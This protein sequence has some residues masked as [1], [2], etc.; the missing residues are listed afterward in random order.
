VES[1][2]HIDRNPQP[3]TL[4]KAIDAGRLRAGKKKASLPPL[5]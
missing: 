4:H 2:D 3:N 1:L 5:R